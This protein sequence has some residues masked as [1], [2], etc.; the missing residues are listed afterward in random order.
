M[1]T[2]Q[3]WAELLL[4]MN[5]AGSCSIQKKEQ[6]A[7]ESTCFFFIFII[8][9]SIHFGGYTS[10]KATCVIGRFTVG[11]LGDHQ[12]LLPS[13]VLPQG[14][15]CVL[16]LCSPRA[17][18]VLCIYVCVCF[19]SHS[20]NRMRSGEIGSGSW[21]RGR[22]DSCNISRKYRDVKHTFKYTKHHS[23]STSSFFFFGVRL[24]NVIRADY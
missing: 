8:T 16:F 24:D 20:T 7:N 10:W 6:R 14:R 15:V 4:I 5:R 22:V 3:S 1:S 19:Q 23:L 9:T 11:A 13:S 18:C 21:F 2:F 17:V 12:R